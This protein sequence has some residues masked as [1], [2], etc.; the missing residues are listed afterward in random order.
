MSKDYTQFTYDGLRE[1]GMTV[2]PASAELKSELEKIGETMTQ[3][4]LDSAGDKG[5]TIVDA[6]K[7]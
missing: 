1:G 5:K 4:W 2:E 3:E 6:F 7:K